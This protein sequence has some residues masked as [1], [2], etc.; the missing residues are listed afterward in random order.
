[1]AKPSGPLRNIPVP[2]VGLCS[3]CSNALEQASAKGQRFWRCRLAESD[4]AFRRY[5][6]LP[7][8]DCS[9][10]QRGQPA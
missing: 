1:M 4:S 10:F 8:Q 3:G 9:G 7:V 2:Q 6:P 5:P